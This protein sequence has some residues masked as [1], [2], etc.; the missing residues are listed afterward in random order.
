MKINSLAW[1]VGS[2]L[3]TFFTLYVFSHKKILCFERQEEFVRGKK[4]KKN[5][6]LPKVTTLFVFSNIS[7]QIHHLLT[8]KPARLERK[9]SPFPLPLPVSRGRCE[10]RG[11]WRRGAG[12]PAALACA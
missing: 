9:L 6:I 11:S 12:T 1:V 2:P 4:K 10:G 8:L 5:H 7:E 3:L